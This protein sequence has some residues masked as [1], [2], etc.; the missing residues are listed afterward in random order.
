MKVGAVVRQVDANDIWF[1]AS[2]ENYTA[3]ALADNQRLLVRRTMQEWMGL[4]P[5][6][7]FRRVHRGLIVNLDRVG[8]IERAS[9]DAT[10]LHVAGDSAAPFEVKRRHW[11]ALRVQLD[12]WRTAR[13]ERTRRTAKQSVAVLPF[14]NLTRDAGHEVFCDGI[15]EELLNVLARIPGLHVAARTSS[16]HFRGRNLPIAEIA[17][18]LAVEFVVEGSLRRAGRRVRITAQLIDAAS[19]YHLWTDNF[20]R[21]LTD[22]LAVQEEIAAQIARRLQLRLR[23]NAGPAKPVDPRA[24]RLA[25]EGRHYWSLRS[26]DGFAR[27]ETAF[28]SALALDPAFA[29]AHA[30]LADLAVVRA[31]YRLADG[32][33]DAT[34]DLAVARTAAHAALERDPSLGEPHAAL[35]FAAFHAGRLAESENHFARALALNPNDATGYQFYAWAL[36]G[37]GRL[38]RGLVEYAKS[39]ALDPLSFINLDRYAAML[40]LARRFA[41]ALEVNERAAALRP[42]VFVGN[43]S[44]RATI[45]LA[46]GRT[47][48]AAALARMVRDTARPSPFRRTSDADAIFVLQQAGCTAEAADYAAAELARLPAENYLRGFILAALGRDREAIA[49]AAHAPSI[50]LPFLFW[51]DLWRT[52]RRRREFAG[53]ISRLGRTGEYRAARAAPLRH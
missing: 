21:E 1:V 35:G 19:G 15:S 28:R 16:F 25:L 43:I 22:I 13:N 53:L 7:Q 33:T 6:S 4:L 23:D 24:H 2:C 47:G 50:M 9:P 5:P 48:E 45:L 37:R 34:A 39:I 51:S 52:A 18:Q 31:M 42:D 30:G 40:A 32:A 41:D 29:R 17:R 14:A 10:R 38:D 11:P 44:Q 27:A 20:D 49:A 3:V 12:A 36:A 8:R 26:A 46:L